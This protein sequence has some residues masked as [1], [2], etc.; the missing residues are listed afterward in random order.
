MLSFK[1]FG[2][3]AL[4]PL[5]FSTAQSQETKT[6]SVKRKND[7]FTISEKYAALKTD[8]N[9][10]HGPYSASISSYSEKG[11]FEQGIKTGV[12]EAYDGSKLVQKYDFE[13]HTFLQD[14]VHKMISS[15]QQLDETGQTVKDLNGVGVYLGGDAKIIS[16]LVRSV[17]YP[18]DAQQNNVQGW[19]VIEAKIDKQ[20]KLTDEKAISNNGYGLEVEGLRVFRMLPPDWL[21]VFVEGKAV[22]VRV[23]FKIAFRLSN[24]PPLKN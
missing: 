16:V 19:V 21:P 18:A 8:P 20:G 14:D 11:Q 10:K 7:F 23:Q 22:D 5:M 6:V 12:W 15:V 3:V 17:R 2:L 1:T 13:T 4:L 9:I 24:L